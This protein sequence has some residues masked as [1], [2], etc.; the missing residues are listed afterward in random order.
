MSQMEFITNRHQGGYLPASRPETKGA[1]YSS[2]A[3]APNGGL[4]IA[5]G[6]KLP[7]DSEVLGVS[8][9]RIDALWADSKEALPNLERAFDDVLAQ[10]ASDKIKLCSVRIGLQ[11]FPLVH[12]AEAKG[13]RLMDVLNVYLSRAQPKTVPER[14][15]NERYRI[16]ADRKEIIERRE[17]ALEIGAESFRHSSRLYEDPRIP[18][19]K[20]NAFYRQLLDYFLHKEEACT[21]LALDEAER[22]AGFFLGLED[23]KNKNLAYLWMLAAAPL[24]R[25]KGLGRLLLNNFLREMH[26]RCPLGEIGTQ[27]NN[28]A[29]NGLYQSAGLPLVANVATLHRWAP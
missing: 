23:E 16:T 5:M 13:F 15:R 19:K 28:P 8:C 3:V 12:M 14:A 21:G 6:R 25:G 18:E 1:E 11:A 10:M 17:E 4:A 27:A 9:A 22:V 26:L 20:A 7:W 29:A 2:T 24:H